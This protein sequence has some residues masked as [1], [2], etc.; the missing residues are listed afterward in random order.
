MFLFFRWSFW[1]TWNNFHET[2]RIGRPWRWW[3]RCRKSSH[4]AFVGLFCLSPWS[5]GRSPTLVHV[6]YQ[7]IFPFAIGSLSLYRL[8]SDWHHD[9]SKSTRK[10]EET[11][12]LKDQSM[13]RVPKKKDS[14]NFIRVV[15]VFEEFFFF[16]EIAQ[17]FEFLRKTDVFEKWWLMIW[18]NFFESAV[19]TLCHVL[20]KPHLTRQF[21]LKTKVFRFFLALWRRNFFKQFFSNIY[22]NKFWIF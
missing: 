10:F 21:S 8:C 9:L 4:S 15:C 19:K 18:R 7:A 5:C 3:L 20:N 14:D 1:S 6:R 13:C 16:C 22:N 11:I 12:L 2:L 17:C